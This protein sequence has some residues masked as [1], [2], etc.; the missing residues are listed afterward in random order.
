[1]TPTLNDPGRVREPML[2]PATPS[3]VPYGAA[4]PVL[5]PPPGRGR[6]P[7]GPAGP[8]PRRA[9]LLPR[10][11]LRRR[12]ALDPRGR[13]AARHPAAA[14]VPGPARGPPPPDALPRQRRGP[15]RPR[16]H[17]LAVPVGARRQPRLPAGPAHGPAAPL[18]QRAGPA[19]EAVPGGAPQRGGDHRRARPRRVHAD[20]GLDGLRHPARDEPEDRE[21][22]RRAL[23]HRD[24]ALDHRLRRHHAGGRARAA[25]LDRD[26]DRRHL[27]VLPAG[28][29]GVPPG[30][31]GAP[32]M[33]AMRP[34]AA[35]RGRGPL[36]G[37]RA[38]PEH[39]E[40]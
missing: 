22:R 37:V 32:P 40:R 18:L 21:L 2:T 17:R 14:R 29:G 8:R 7:G 4:A 30:R 25:A 10:H 1:M 38:A 9:R 12:R 36:Q 35:R 13:P 27:A 34:A 16:G 33:P 24:D 19:Q 15:G 26:D 6:V 3:A 20:G 31:Q 11:H 5:R 23:L 39:P 28:A